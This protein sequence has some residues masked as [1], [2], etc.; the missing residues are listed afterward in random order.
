MES[1]GGSVNPPQ[2]ALG[3]RIP[4]LSCARPPTASRPVLSSRLSSNRQRRWFQRPE[5]AGSNPA[6]RIV[7]S[8]LTR[9]AVVFGGV[10]K[11]LK[12]LVC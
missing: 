9:P 4:L 11:G 10:P 3:V 2:V 6:S 5:V 8:A 12:G 1:R 7:R